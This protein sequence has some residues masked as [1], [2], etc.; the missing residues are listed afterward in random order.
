MT[1][2]SARLR[3]PP[4]EGAERAAGARAWVRGAHHR[5]HHPQVSTREVQRSGSRR[6]DQDHE[7]SGADRVT[8]DRVTPDRVTGGAAPGAFWSIMTS[9]DDRT[10]V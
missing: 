6:L 7:R 2:R 3:R 10:C 8:G 5:N 9:P 4:I 1:D